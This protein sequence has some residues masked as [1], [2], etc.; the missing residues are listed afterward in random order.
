MADINPTTNA[1]QLATLYTQGA[2]SQINTQTKAA[3]ATSD[4]LTK[5]QTALNTFNTALTTLS[6]KSSVQQSSASFSG[7]YATATAT[8]SATAGTYSVFVEQVATA[9][10][11]A[12][13]D[14]PAV[15]V[16]NGGPITVNLGNGNS[17]TVDLAAADQDGDGTLSQTEI[18]RAINQAAGNGGQVTAGIVTVAGKT[19]MILTSGSTGLDGAITLDASGLPGGALQTALSSSQTL[20]AAQDATV[21]LGQQGT[22]IKLTQSSNT[23]TAI[24]GVTMTVT[25]AMSTG[26]SPMT[27]TVASDTSGTASNVKSFVDAYNALKSTLDSLTSNGDADNGVAAA[28]LASDSGVRALQDHIKTALRQ[29]FGGS[30]LMS[31]GVAADRDGNLSLDN[32]KLT[33]AVAAKPDALNTVFG[34]TSLTNSSGL[35]GSLGTYLKSWTDSSSGL[36]KNR[37]DTVQRTQKSLTTRQTKLDAQYDSYYQRYLKQFTALQALQAQMSQSTSTLSS[38]FPS[39][40]S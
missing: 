15:S 29:S 38:L 22:G 39:S 27:L 17:F 40:S 35:L 13:Q 6:S 8:S 26:S 25:Q 36:I 4:A 24:D 18:A 12:F 5:L 19:Q 20:V 16:D 37:Q 33:K 14:L 3:K 7:S 30:T 1:T 32:D 10:Q 34:K 9:H 2:Q 21:W 28:A 11:I 31:F 23:F